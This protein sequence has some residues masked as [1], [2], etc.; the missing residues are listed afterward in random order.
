MKKRILQVFMAFAIVLTSFGGLFQFDLTVSAADDNTTVTYLEASDLIYDLMETATTFIVAQHKAMGGT[1]YAY[2]A[3]LLEESTKDAA[4]GV[5]TEYNFKPG[6]RLVLFTLAEEGGRIKKTEKVILNSDSGCIRDPNVSADGTKCVFSWKQNA[7]DDFHIYEMELTSGKYEYKQLTFGSGVADFECLY[8]P[9]GEIMFSSTR[10]TQTVD[11]WYTQVANI[12]KMKADG[13]DIV[14]LG[15]DQVHTTYPTLTDDGRVIYTR[16]DYNDRTQMF[17][18]GVFQMNPD[19]TNQTE[20]YGNNSNFPTTLMHTRQVPGNSSKYI[21]IVTGHHT[22]QAGKLCYVDV[23]KERDGDDSVTFIFGDSYATKEDDVDKYGQSGALY[24]Y[25]YA[26]NDTQ[27]L[28]SYSASGWASDKSST[29]FG[30][31]LMDSQTGEKVEIIA[32]NSVYPSAQVVPVKTSEVFVRPSSVDYASSLGTYYIADVYTGEAVEGV[33]RGTVKQIRVVALDYRAYAVGITDGAGSGTSDMY[34]PISTGNGSWDV[35]QV[36]GVATVYEDG[37]ALFTVPSETPVYFQLLDKDGQ[38]IQTMRSWSTLM[39]NEVYS[40]VGCHENNNTTP[41]AETGI[42]M[43]IKAGVET[44]KAESW[45]GEDHDPYAVKEGFDYLEEVQPILDANCI[46]CHNN[47][48]VSYQMINA[49]AVKESGVTSNFSNYEEEVIFAKES[50][51]QYKMSTTNNPE[52]GW[53]DVGFTGSWST[54]QAG[55]GSTSSSKTSWTGDKNW[56]FIRKTFTINDLSNYENARIKLNIFYDDTPVI[57]INGHEVYNDD[58]NWTTSYIDVFCDAKYLREGENVIAISVNQHTGGRFIDT[59]LSILTPSKYEEKVVFGT[60]SMW[61]YYIS[62]TNDAVSGW[63]NVGFTGS[64]S[65]GKA[66]FGDRTN[67]ANVGTTWT[68]VSSSDEGKTW[69]FI[70]KTF[71]ID[72]LSAYKNAKLRFN[73]FYDDSP[74]I[75]VNGQE[76]F[77]DDNKWVDKFVTLTFDAGDMLREGENVIAIS[78]NQHT[79]GRFI[80]TSFSILVEGDK[81]TTIAPFSLEGDNIGAARMSRYFPLSYLVLTASK[82]NSSTNTAVFDEWVGT[83]NNRFTNWVSSMSVPEMLPANTYGS[84]TSNIIKILREGHNGVTLTDEELRVLSAWIDLGVPAYNEYDDNNHWDVAEKRE[85]EEEQNK[86]DY[87]DMLNV[88]ARMSIAGTLPEGTISATFTDASTKQTYTGSADGILNLYVPVKYADGDSIT[89]ILPEGVTYIGFTINSK[90]GESIIYCPD[91]VF[92]YKISNISNS[93]TTMSKSYANTTN[94]VTVRILTEEEL[95]EKRNLAENSYDYNASS[96]SSSKAY[97]HVSASTECR[98]EVQYFA[99]NAIDGFTNNTSHGTY[100][101]QSWGPENIANQWFEIKFGRT[102]NAEELGIVI[103]Y[104]VGHDTWF[105]TAKVEVTYKD[106]TTSTQNITIKWTGEEQIFDLDLDKPITK[107][108]LYDLVADTAGGWAAF[109]EVSVYGTEVTGD[110][111]ADA[112]GDDEIETPDEPNIPDVPDEPNEP[113]EPTEDQTADIVMPD[114]WTTVAEADAIGYVFDR[115]E[116]V[117]VDTLTHAADI[118]RANAGQRIV[119]YLT[120]DYTTSNRI[121]VA[122]AGDGYAYDTIDLSGGAELVIDGQSKYS[123]MSSSDRFIHFGSSVRGGKM[124]FRNL[125][126]LGTTVSGGSMQTNEGSL[127]ML[128]LENLTIS[129]PNPSNNYSMVLKTN[130]IMDGVTRDCGKLA[131]V[132]EFAAGVKLVIKNSTIT[133]VNSGSVFDKVYGEIEISNTYIDGV[134]YAVFDNV[135]GKVTVNSVTIRNATNMFNKMQSGAE[136]LVKNADASLT[137]AMFGPDSAGGTVCIENADVTA[138]YVFELAAGD[139]T[140][141]N[142]KARNIERVF[143]NLK[144]DLQIEN[145]DVVMSAAFYRY[146]AGNIVINGGEFTST[147]DCIFYFDNKDSSTITINDGSFTVQASN[148]NVIYQLSNGYGKSV[149]INGGTFNSWNKD[150][151]VTAS[152]IGNVKAII[153]ATGDSIKITSGTF[154][155]Y[156]DA[157]VT[158]AERGIH[159]LSSGSG[160]ISVLGGTFNGGQYV[161]VHIAVEFDDATTMKAA[162]PTDKTCVLDPTTIKGASIRTVENSSGIRFHGMVNKDAIDYLKAFYNTDAVYSG[163]AIVPAD[164]LEKTGGVFTFAALSEAGCNWATTNANG[165][166]IDNNDGTYTVRLALVDIQSEN[167]DRKFVAIAYVYADIDGDGCVSGSD[168]VIYADEYSYERSIVETAK[169]AL[170][171]V[172]STSAGSYTTAVSGYYYVRNNDGTYSKVELGSNE[173][174]YSRYSAS[175]IAVLKS[176]AK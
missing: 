25:P 149:T 150:A 175:Q 69:L 37:S 49:S 161:N 141:K 143:Y 4:T 135:Y 71:T 142:I 134:K 169:A 63:N 166:L 140:I 3:G 101:V 139:I 2:T 15:Y 116:K 33:A 121:G 97:P 78:I 35:K 107:L 96:G 145:A 163:I 17:V 57:Y 112:S 44:L 154:N 58:G 65:V 113:D 5:G 46:S 59:S 1:H 127:S 165:G 53:N 160:D 123:M 130:V 88:Y 41:P 159:V 176:Y 22:Y 117:Y 108:R 106:G 105:K 47:K 90:K 85:A 104:D 109:T 162:M 146:L 54:A 83:A 170:A 13:S 129:I 156:K 137:N 147:G 26:I 11:C 155:L 42:T 14:R 10:C 21:S 39:P 111:F 30:L 70:R 164:Y 80:D 144:G 102:V 158:L 93:V 110:D 73:I 7:S 76:I 153:Y 122:D 50:K 67:V 27:F 174:K 128:T 24:Q 43:A 119:L 103:R 31:W 136:V 34:S 60:E 131:F 75:Y 62:S 82:A 9:N 77:R 168:V 98:N 173:V 38:M 12:Y 16:W 84:S 40:C 29:P 45:Q 61:E 132:R 51:W 120:S 124:T 115:S 8:L 66:G 94:Y 125:T 52:A 56:I 99:L 19:G 114:G 95:T 91:G 157:G 87:Y 64:W 133:N 20:L 74:V 138:K 172:Q 48:E 89:V 6:S 79:G 72:D 148:K 36:L 92:T 126:T 68:K 167:L 152:N 100:P 55:F 28:V 81:D 23:S 118:A 151:D 86:R 32:G 18:Q 171:D